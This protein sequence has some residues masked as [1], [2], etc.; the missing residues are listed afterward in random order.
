MYIRKYFIFAASLFLMGSCNKYLDVKPKGKL[1]PGTVTDFDH[2]LDNSNQME[3]NFLDNNR[4]SLLSYLTDNVEITEGQAKVGFILNSHPNLNRYYGYSYRQPYNNPEISDYFWGTGSTIGI[5]AQVSYFNNVIEG[6]KGVGQLTPEDELL[7]KKAV[8]QATMAR[9]WCFFNANLVFGPVYKPGTDNST[10]TIPYVVNPD[11]NTALPDLST[12]GEVV[13]RVLQD[14]YAAVPDLPE[15]SSWPSRA[16]K[17]AGYAMLAY[18]HLFTQK[19][20]SVAYYANLAWTANAANPSKVLYDYNQFS[21]ATPGNLVSSQILTPQDTYLNVVNSREMLFYRATDNNAGIGSSLSYPSAGL[22][23][24]FDQANDL[25]FKFTYITTAGYK[26]SLGGGYDDG[27]RISHY[28]PRKMKL[29][30]GFSWPEVLLMRAEGYARTNRPDLAVADLNTLR[31]FRYKTGTPPLTT[32]TVDEVIKWVLEERRRELPIGGIKRFV[33]LKRLMLDN[34]KPWA[35]SQIVHTVGA[36]NYTG[37]IDSKD[38]IVPITNVVLRFNPGWG[39][40]LDT[41]PF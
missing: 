22:I 32:G 4:G 14:L 34:G 8:A 37:N 3:W 5:Y 25:R 24:L 33:D 30:E 36:Q 26:T 2:L 12:S 17:A 13:T 23:S 38:F 10:K 7:A 1:I 15:I 40:P 35:K 31:Q 9:A 21:W 6:I 19:F 20:D 41:R 27:M 28:R 11:I 18:C 16:N 39:I 29:T